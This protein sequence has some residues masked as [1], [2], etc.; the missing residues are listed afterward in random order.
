[1]IEWVKLFK[2]SFKIYNEIYIMKSK[3]VHYLG[4][5]FQGIRIL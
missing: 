3:H 4:Q 5:L 1:M 2:I